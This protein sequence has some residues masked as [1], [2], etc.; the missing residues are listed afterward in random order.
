MGFNNYYVL[1]SNNL[2]EKQRCVAVVSPYVVRE[3]SRFEFTPYGVKFESVEADHRKN[4]CCPIV[5]T[6]LF[7]SSM[8]PF[9]GF[10]FVG[11]MIFAANSSEQRSR[12]A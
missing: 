5:A 1:W 4:V 8:Q 2:A 6:R 11:L 7:T 9:S 10:S 3:R 12:R